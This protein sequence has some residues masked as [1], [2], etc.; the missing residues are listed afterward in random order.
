MFWSDLVYGRVI[1]LLFCPRSRD[2]LIDNGLCQTMSNERESVV[3]VAMHDVMTMDYSRQHTYH[4]QQV[5]LDN[6]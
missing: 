4:R 6:G 2:E 1:V 3:V 5:I